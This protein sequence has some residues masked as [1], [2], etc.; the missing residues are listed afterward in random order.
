[1]EKNMKA[2][3]CSGFACTG[4]NSELGFGLWAGSVGNDGM[5][6]SM[7]SIWGGGLGV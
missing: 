1:M 3:S 6:K 5:D 7:E 2:L 4:L